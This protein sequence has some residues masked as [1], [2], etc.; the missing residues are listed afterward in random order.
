MPNQ[1]LTVNMI[2]NEALRVLHQKCNFIGSTDRQYDSSFGR[3]GAKIGDTLRV[4]K[5]VQYTVRSG[6]VMSAQDTV[7]ES[8]NLPVTNVRGVDM[9][10][11]STE[12]AL[13]L[14][15]FSD[16]I[17]K[18]AVSVLAANIEAIYYDAMYKSVWNMINADAQAF[19]FNVVQDAR[20]R[21]T[22]G[23]AP[24]DQ[25]Y[26]TMTPGHATAL[27]KDT[28][29]LF[30]DS[31]AVRQ[32]Y[33]EGVLGKTGGLTMQE[34]TLVP[35]HTTGTAA[36]VTGY[37]VNGA[38]QTSNTTGLGGNPNSQTITLA[39]DTGTTT[40]LRGDVVTIAGVFAV[41]P[42]TKASTG[43]LQQFVVIA[44]SGTSATSLQLSP[45][46]VTTGGY[47]N[48][49]AAPAN[50]APISKVGAGASELLTTS[51]AYHKDAFTFATAD[52]PLP[53]G[54]DFAA[55][56]VMDGI[57]MSVIRDFSIS[58][59]SFPCRIDVLFGFAALRPELATRIHAD[60]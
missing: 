51:M 35:S 7:E 37:L 55:R 46:I 24:L 47:Q 16:R 45:G 29:G 36:A 17:I 5:P 39:V 60:G 13:S 22:E 59:R 4:R 20:Q 41:H 14:D 54:V 40:F 2:T 38:N 9:N 21:L 42:E 50:D 32:Q 8:V 18:P 3:S 28:K 27:I 58:D 15:D 23:L 43:R 12:L 30:Q 31:D 49:T 52:L 11:T 10:F 48:V 57:S 26:C 6:M 34:N 33:R 44:N 56:K 25:R 53:E 19:S 1:L